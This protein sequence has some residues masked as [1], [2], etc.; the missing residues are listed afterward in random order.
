MGRDFAMLIIADRISGVRPRTR[1]VHFG[2]LPR[3]RH[4]PGV[5]AESSGF[6]KERKDLLWHHVS[7]V[8]LGRA[9]HG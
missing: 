8:H 2:R 1:A 9:E 5:G 3:R 4:L 6:R 7:H